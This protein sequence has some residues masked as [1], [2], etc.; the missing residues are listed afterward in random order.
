MATLQKIRN[1]GPLLLIIVGIAMLAF[2][3]G[4][5]L[6]S[7][8][9]F[10]NR[11]RDKIAVISGNDI[12]FRDFEVSKE[13][14]SR[15]YEMQ[16]QNISSEIAQQQIRNQVW[17]WYLLENTFG[18]EAKAAGLRVTEEELMRIN[19]AFAQPNLYNPSYI[20]CLKR[21][22]SIELMQ[23]KYFMLFRGL[24][25]TN[26]LDA[27]FA[28]NARQADVNVE[29]VCK[30]YYMIPDSLVTVSSSDIKNYYKLHKEEFKQEP[31]RTISYIAFDIV[32][33]ETD[34]KEAAELMDKLQEEFKTT[35]NIASF[36]N[37]YSDVPFSY[38]QDY[39]EESVPAQYKDFAF[40]KGAKAGQ[41]TELTFEDN[42]YSMA[43]IMKAGYSLPDSIELQLIT[44]EEETEA[45]SFWYPISVLKQ[46]QTTDVFD[47]ICLS[48]KGEQV[49]LSVRGEERP[50][51]VLDKSPATP[52]VQL[53]ILER[54]VTPS[55]NTTNAI[56]SE[57]SQFIVD[58]NTEEK[59]IAAAKEQD[60][61]YISDYKLTK[62][63]ENIG[64]FE[65]SR[66]IVQWAFDAKEGQ[67]SE[68]YRCNDQYIVA[69]LTEANENEYI[70]ME[71]IQSYIVMD[72]INNKK[73]ELLMSDA[74]NVQTLEQA[75][76]IFGTNIETAEHI[77]LASSR[78]GNK[79]AEPAVVGT[80]MATAD[81]TI[82]GPIQGNVGVYY[83]KTGAKVIANNEIDIEAEKT[84]LTQNKLNTMAQY[85]MSEI[86]S[87]AKIEDNRINFY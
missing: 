51:K 87:N 52:K 7:S 30:P 16:N 48:K 36:V 45:Q 14:L 84:Q 37:S 32:P 29:Y 42:V 31:Y 28:F 12:S 6:N 72:V 3:L 76:E 5:F 86:I 38:D 19:P 82:A 21:G 62:N 9:S 74:E 56:S 33:S 65:N 68:S 35:E 85:L 73:A 10:F 4:D 80:A 47:K 78:F 24:M 18:E 61:N 1:H 60:L 25:R 54:K 2:I 71:E 8:S 43:R 13:H 83:I 67:I 20:T 11:N 40:A 81:N 44:N 39:S 66:R 57:I 69:L 53:A 75:A 63:T 15:F 77:N 49:V 34:F 79:G 55:D 46:E 58:N 41:V 17:Q 70:P 26:S 23:Q 59:F 27:K 50:F 64:S 22:T